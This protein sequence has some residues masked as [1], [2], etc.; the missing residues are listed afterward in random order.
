MEY[1]INLINSNPTIIYGLLTSLGFIIIDTLLGYMLAL[2]NGNF[3][4]SKIPQF[5][6]TG[7]LPYVGGLIIIAGFSLIIT[8]IVPVFIT[9]VGL[10][11]LKF[12][13]EII[14]DKAKQLFS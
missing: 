13:K 11:S 1:I 8:E 7:V 2:K 3:D 14:L 6:S 12:G 4:I 10:V 5:L 9:C